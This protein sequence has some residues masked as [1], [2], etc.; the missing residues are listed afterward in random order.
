[1]LRQQAAI[2]R[3]LASSFDVQRIRRQLFDIAARCDDLATSLGENPPRA[4][5]RPASR[6]TS[7]DSHEALSSA[8]ISLARTGIAKKGGRPR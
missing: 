4:P 8:S 1:M 6:P 7:T 3:T 2:L 5:S